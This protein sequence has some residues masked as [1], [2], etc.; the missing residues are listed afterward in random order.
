MYR[1]SSDIAPYITH[2]DLPQFHHQIEE[3]WDDLVVLGEQARTLD[4]RLSMHPAQYIVLNSPDEGVAA[5]GIRDFAYHACFL[6]ALGTDANAKIVTHTGGVY[7]DRATAAERFVRR[8]ESLP[9]AVQSRLVLENDETSWAVED[10]LP[11]H[12]QTGIPLVFDTLHHMVNNPSR[13][14]V[15]DAFR[16]CLA[17]WPA[18]QVPKIHFSTQ[19]RADREISRR[20]PDAGTRSVARVPAKLG[21]HDDWIDGNEFI[22]FLAGAGDVSFDVMLEAKQKQLALFRLR[23]DLL[24]AGRSGDIW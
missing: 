7:G 20:A 24:A 2:P 3:C 22:D 6:D 12:E 15:H 13:I 16:F 5:A 4:L 17:T 1:I 18:E 11:I 23:D 14:A 21:Q 9:S 19:R 10:V 8:Y